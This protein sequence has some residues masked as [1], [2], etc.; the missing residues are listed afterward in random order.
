MILYTRKYIYININTDN[1][2][3]KVTIK[4][5]NKICRTFT[6]IHQTVYVDILYMS[7]V[8]LRYLYNMWLYVTEIFIKYTPKRIT[9][10]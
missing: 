6:V 1:H 3:M 10:T 2:A 4:T 8:L 7:I 9:N 5:A